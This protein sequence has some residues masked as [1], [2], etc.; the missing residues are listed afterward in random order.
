MLPTNHPMIVATGRRGSLTQF[1]VIAETIVAEAPSLLSAVDKAFKL[2]FICGLQ[3]EP[4]VSHVWQLIQ[5][6]VYDI[7]DEFT[8][9]AGVFDVKDF[10]KRA[11]KSRVQ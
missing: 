11:K 9:Y 2:H 7:N 4:K 5:K 3:Y 8:T 10:I 6:V 1:F